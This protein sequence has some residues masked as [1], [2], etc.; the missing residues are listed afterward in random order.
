LVILQSPIFLGDLHVGTSMPEPYITM[1]TFAD[2]ESATRTRKGTVDCVVVASGVAGR[3]TD[4][5]LAT[6]HSYNTRSVHG[7]DII[8]KD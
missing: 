1:W 6:F 3:F 5:I 4:Q 2:E 8:C 7:V